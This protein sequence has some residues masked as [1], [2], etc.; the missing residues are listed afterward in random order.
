MAFA[1]CLQILGQASADLI[2]DQSDTAV[3]CG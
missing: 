3:W 1:L 2:E